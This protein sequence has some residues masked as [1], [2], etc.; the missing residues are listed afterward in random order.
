MSKIIS[1]SIFCSGSACVGS[2]SICIG[3]GSSS[4]R[5]SREINNSSGTSSIASSAN[6]ADHFLSYHSECQGMHSKGPA[7]RG[8]SARRK[9]DPSDPSHG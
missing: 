9:G 3:T 2:D 5:S 7:E 6:G 4:E 8:L 1:S